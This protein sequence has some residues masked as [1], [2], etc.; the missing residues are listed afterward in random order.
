MGSFNNV[1][2]VLQVYPQAGKDFLTVSGPEILEATKA[3]YQV[4]LTER[5]WKEA[6]LTTPMSVIVSSE[7]TFQN[8]EV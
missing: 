6:D 3:S 5:Y 1:C 8:I 7:R 4:K 2:V